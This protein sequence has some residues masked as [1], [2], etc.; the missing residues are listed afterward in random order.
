MLKKAFIILSTQRSG[1]TLLCKDLASTQCMGNPDEHLLD[2]LDGR[3][4][5]KD[6]FYNRCHDKS[7]NFGLK[8]MANYLDEAMLMLSKGLGFEGTNLNDYLLFLNKTYDKVVLIYLTRD[9][10][11]EQAL[12]RIT[13]KK[14]NTWHNLGNDVIQMNGGSTNADDTRAKRKVVIEQLKVKDINDSVLDI[15][16]ENQYLREV[17]AGLDDQVCVKFK[18]NYN[19]VVYNYQRLINFIYDG[20][21]TVDRKM[22]KISS[23]DDA[24]RAKEIYFQTVGKVVSDGCVNLLRDSAI[25]LEEFDTFK[26]TLM[27]QMAH[28]LRPDGA[29]IKEKLQE[30]TSKE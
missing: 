10:Y 27:M 26:S 21:V 18:T 25:L 6:E 12:S 23:E 28:N 16:K 29:F 9:D 11:F 15:L 20:H 24:L 5:N 22:K 14:T 19:E 4:F 8:L 2:Y 30:Y 17:Y 1:S 7:G 13:A 3:D